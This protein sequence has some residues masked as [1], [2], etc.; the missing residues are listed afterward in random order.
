MSLADALVCVV[1][2][3][4]RYPERRLRLS[5]LL[6]QCRNRFIRRIGAVCTLLQAQLGDPQTCLCLDDLFSQLRVLCI[7]HS[8]GLQDAQPRL[9]HAEIVLGLLH[10]EVRNG[11]LQFGRIVVLQALQI[12]LGIPKAGLRLL[13]LFLQVC[14]LARTRILVGEVGQ[15][16]L[17]R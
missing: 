12:V 13:D 4:L 9:G 1:T 6:F 7:G 11:N 10:R 8:A 17:C 16:R 15:V 2:V 14:Q 5:H 3:G